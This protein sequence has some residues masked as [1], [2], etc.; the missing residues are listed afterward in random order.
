[1]IVWHVTAQLSGQAVLWSSPLRWDAGQGVAQCG[2]EPLLGIDLCLQL[3][4]LLLLQHQ[5][6]MFGSQHVMVYWQRL[7]GMHGVKQGASMS[8]ITAD[9]SELSGCVVTF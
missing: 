7:L 3:R 4:C 9:S 6:T 2:Y 1:M 8:I 5:P